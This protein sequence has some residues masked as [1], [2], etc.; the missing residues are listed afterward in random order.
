MNCLTWKNSARRQSETQCLPCR[1]LLW[2]ALFTVGSTCAP[3]KS[4]NERKQNKNA[5]GILYFLAKYFLS[6]SRFIDKILSFVFQIH[7]NRVAQQISLFLFFRV[8]SKE[9]ISF[10]KE[11]KT[12]VKQKNIQYFCGLSFI[13]FCKLYI[14][15]FFR[16][17]CLWVVW[18]LVALIFCRF[19]R[20]W[21][22]WY[23]A[24]SSFCFCV[25]CAVYV[26]A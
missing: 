18:W 19:G 3:E 13:P 15:F 22:S 2:T 10:R 6:N 23:R 21:L 5:N 14:I 12:K 17:L 11:M 8:H 20:S 24:P 4:Q 26:S 9:S 25:L 16:L 7:T 1:C